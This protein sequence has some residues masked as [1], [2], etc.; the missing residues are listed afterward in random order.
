MAGIFF[1]WTNAVTPG[2]GDLA[3]IGYLGALQSMNRVILNPV[4]YIVFIGPILTLPL[5]AT[6]YYNSSHSLVFKLLLVASGNYLSGVFLITILGNIPLN[7]LLHKINLDGFSLE[8]AK[9]LRNL[10]ETKWNYFNLI[11]TITSSISF[12]LLIMIGFLVTQ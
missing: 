2:I 11:R 7:N 9:K 10:I 4:F 3:D 12:V 1:T 5:A 6:L 8:N